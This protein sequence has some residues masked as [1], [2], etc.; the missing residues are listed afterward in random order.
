MK[1]TAGNSSTILPPLLKPYKRYCPTEVAIKNQ[2]LD[3]G[4]KHQMTME[5]KWNQDW[6]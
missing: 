5:T 2:N 6:K 4:V 3:A 1:S